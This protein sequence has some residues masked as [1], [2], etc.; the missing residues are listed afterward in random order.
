MHRSMFHATLWQTMGISMRL[1]LST[2]LVMCVSI[3]ALAHH[4]DKEN[5]PVHP[6]IDVIPPLGNSLPMSYRRKYNRPSKWM[7]KIAYHIAPSSQE[8]MAWHRATHRGY[9]KNHSP[10]MVTHYFY[11][12]PWEALRIG[13]RPDTTSENASSMP[14][15]PSPYGNA[16]GSDVSEE[17]VPAPAGVTESTPAPLSDMPLDNGATGELIEPS[18]ALESPSDSSPSDLTPPIPAP[19]AETPTLDPP[20][21]GASEIQAPADVP[22]PSDFPAPAIKPPTSI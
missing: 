7:G 22:V 6:R 9:Y 15:V 17:M 14:T 13:A 19:A 3:P 16:P 11:P 2:T 4:P 5:Q 18:D 10:R 21:A 1:F 8:A 20:A 12:K